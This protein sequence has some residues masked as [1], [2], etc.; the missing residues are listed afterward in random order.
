MSGNDDSLSLFALLV[1]L[2]LGLWQNRQRLLEERHGAKHVHTWWPG[3]PRLSF[4]PVSEKLI[5]LG[6]NPSACFIGGAFLRYELGA[7]LLGLWLMLSAFALLIVE[8]TV[9]RQSLEHGREVLDR[10]EEAALDAE[11]VA[12]PSRR[13]ETTPTGGIATGSD[14]GLEAEIERRRRQMMNDSQGGIIQ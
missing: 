7:G 11:M 1:L 2:P 4:L 3:D 8:W 12:P 5:R 9:W 6:V 14:A 13:P 10:M